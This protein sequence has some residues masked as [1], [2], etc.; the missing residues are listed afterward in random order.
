MQS[1]H[2]NCTIVYLSSR[3]TQLITQ[4]TQARSRHPFFSLGNGD[5]QHKADSE[6]QWYLQPEHLF[7]G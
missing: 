1:T 6:G 2:A 4:L 5:F 3:V 7:I